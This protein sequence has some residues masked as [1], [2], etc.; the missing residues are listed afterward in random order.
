MNATLPA[1]RI[2][3]EIF[4]G[5]NSGR[6]GEVRHLPWS[7]PPTMHGRRFQPA[8]RESSLEALADRLEE[9]AGMPWDAQAPRDRQMG[10]AAPSSDKAVGCS[11]SWPMTTGS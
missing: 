9:L 8:R 11:G 1:T 5:V 4:V 2:R 3:R 6:P 7:A 10:I